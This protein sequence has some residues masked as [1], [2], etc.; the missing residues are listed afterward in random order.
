MMAYLIESEG[1]QLL[2]WAD[3][4]SHYVLS[5]QRPDI[6]LDVDDD[7][8]K[9]AL[10]RERILDMVATDKMF[11]IGFHMPFPGIG[12]VE[13]A[14]TGYRWIPHSYQLNL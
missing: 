6:Y 14:L 7:Q 9:A 12:F 11:V 4:C 13:R 1:K 10:T 2:N 5:V 3:T 8:Q